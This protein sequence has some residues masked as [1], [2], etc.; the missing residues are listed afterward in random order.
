[1]TPTLVVDI[2]VALEILVLI[3][4]GWKFNRNEEIII[5]LLKGIASNQPP[6]KPAVSLKFTLGKVQAE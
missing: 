3:W 2:I 1:M 5:Q 4:Q 6:K